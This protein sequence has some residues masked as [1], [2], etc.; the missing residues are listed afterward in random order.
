M[1]NTLQNYYGKA[2]R[3][4]KN[5]SIPQVKA[6]IAADIHHCT[7]KGEGDKDDRHKYCPSDDDT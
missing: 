1:I 5:T 2:I 3:N 7:R 4:T 6:A